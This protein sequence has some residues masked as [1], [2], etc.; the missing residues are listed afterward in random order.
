MADDWYFYIM[1]YI[2]IM[3]V[4]ICS[5][6]AQ[7]QKKGSLKW[8]DCDSA[9]T[10]LD[11]NDCAA[12]ALAQADAKLNSVYKSILKAYKSDT[13]FIH[14]L[15]TAEELW[16][17]LRDA[18]LKVKFPDGPDYEYGSVQPMCRFSYLTDLTNERIKFLQVWV[19]GIEEGDLCLG[20]VKIK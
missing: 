4:L 7:A 19:D 17:K 15:K 3:L 14:N 13:A 12:E 20:S 18:E 16:I 2:L 5:S 11:L 1:K 8:P 9:K 10:Q 6:Q